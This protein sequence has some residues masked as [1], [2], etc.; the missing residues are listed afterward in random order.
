MKAPRLRMK[1]F[2][3]LT[4]V[5]GLTAGAGWIVLGANPR[6]SATAAQVAATTVRPE[7]RAQTVPTPHTGD[8][9]DDPAIWIHPQTPELSLVLGTDKQGGLHSYNHD[10]S[11]VQLVSAGSHP[12]NVDVLYGFPLDGRA[13]DLAVAGV[14]ATNRM[15]VKIWAIHP[16]TRRLADVTDGGQ[17]RV[18][19][20]VEPYGSCGYRSARTGKYYFFV[21]DKTG[22]VEQ[23]ELAD[24][25][26]GKIKAAKVRSFKVGSLVEGCTA[27][28]DLGFF[29]LGEETVGIW[30]FG[31]EPDAGKEG[32]L[33]ARVGESGL[34]ADVEGLT[35]YYAT[36]GRGYL[37][38]SSQG[39][40]TFK[41]YERGGENR[42]LLTVDPK[43][44]RIDDVNDTD[45]ICVTSCPTT[46]QFSQG[47]FVVQDGSNAGGNQNFK[48]YG[49]EDIAGTNL[50]IDTTWPPRPPAPA[51]KSRPA[52]PASIDP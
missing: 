10:G 43:A 26:A 21:N 51:L 19:D 5:L 20:G 41:V 38:A 52:A 1:T 37:I 44:G 29:Y 48:L 28:D 3:I 9:A 36:Q 11:A 35:I 32:K 4:V 49:W 34:T 6:P 25:G 14:R 8:A 30:K 50:L 18:L 40:N 23:Y 42:Y 27:D 16:E 17:I 47:V 15:G 46:K 31:A 13:V 2:S 7:A 24:A 39:N 45:G 33:I 22:R 12:N